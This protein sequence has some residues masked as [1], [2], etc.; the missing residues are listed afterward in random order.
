MATVWDVL[1]EMAKYDGSPTAHEDVIANIKKHGHSA[2]MSDAWCTM[3]IMSAFYNAGAI[4]LIGGYSQISGNLKKKAEKLGI[5]KSGSS[6]I[7]PGDIIVYGS[8]GKPN[9]T[10]LCVGYDV[11]VSGNYAQA[12]AK[13]YK[14]SRRTYKNRKTVMGRVRPKYAKMGTMD[15]LQLMIAACDVILN[16]YSTKTNREKCLAVFGSANAKAIQ[17]EADRIINATT[18]PMAV[19]IIQ[20]RA[21]KGVEYRK[22]RL[23]KY[24]T[25]AQ[26]KVNEINALRTHSIEQAVTDV[27]ADK[28]GKEAVR[29]ALL[30]FNGYDADKVQAAVDKRL[31]EPQKPPDSKET[32]S[33]ISLFRDA[34]RDTKDVDGLQGDCVIVKDGSGNALIMD[35]MRSGALDKIY[36]E[37]AGCNTCLY[38]SHPHSDHM[39]QNANTLVKS[40]KIKKCYLPAESTIHS[41]YKE[42]YKTLVSDCKNHNVEVTVL[43]QGSGFDVGG[44]HGEVLYQQ[45]NPKTDSVNMR[46]L[47]TLITVAGK[48][49]LTCGDHHC[50]TS[51]SGFKYSKHVNFLKSS[52]H[53]LFTGDKDKFIKAVSPE[54]IIGSGWKSWPLNTVGQDKKVKAAQNVY[55]KYGNLFPGDICGRT[56]F[57]IAADGSVTPTAEKNLTEHTIKYSFDGKTYRKTVKT[58]SK[59]TFHA[60][61]SMIPTGGKLL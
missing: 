39:G 26:N 60:V 15:N 41:D 46:S 45:A 56:E 11:T 58:C 53:Q 61:G 7:L 32:G 10:E 5:W 47:C 21:G 18:F 42:R 59:C 27:L 31:S 55:Q 13:D 19:Y 6:D 22:K 23:G 37:I 17:K 28:Y 51:E 38:I 33:I 57:K 14:C 34:A 30:R 43:V 16:V 1:A 24:Y 12:Q 52:H 4:D 50:G 29:R 9:H 25:T 2:S 36:A 8:N 20:G 44:I 49:L 3:T 35:T 40:G 48:T 54:F